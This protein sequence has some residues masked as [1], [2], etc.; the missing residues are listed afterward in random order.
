[1]PRFFNTSG[2]CVPGN[3][4]MLPAAERLTEARK[5]IDM[6]RCYLIDSSTNSAVS[7]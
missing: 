7:G 2:P 4:Y 3:H 6:E 1:M 5:L